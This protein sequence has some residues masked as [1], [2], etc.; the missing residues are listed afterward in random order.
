MTELI[1][2]HSGPFGGGHTLLVFLPFISLGLGIVFI[3]MAAR[4]ETGRNRS[5]RRLP[6]PKEQPLR[7]VHAA[8]LANRRPPRGSGA[9]GKPQA[10]RVRVAPRHLKQ[11]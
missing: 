3:V 5:V 1:L 6:T 2:A 7:H 8:L 11:L 4:D 9:S 10:H